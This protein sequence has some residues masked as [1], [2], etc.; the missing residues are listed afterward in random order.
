MRGPS[1][2]EAKGSILQQ[3]L[4]Y[5]R[6]LD[7]VSAAHCPFLAPAKAADAIRHWDSHVLLKSVDLALCLAV[8]C[9]HV[10]MLRQARAAR[11]EAGRLLLCDVI[12]WPMSSLGRVHFAL[13]KRYTKQ[14]FL[15]GKFWPGQSLRSAHDTVVPDPPGPILVIRSSLRHRDLRFFNKKSRP[16]RNDYITA[17][18]TSLCDAEDILAMNTDRFQKELATLAQSS[19]AESRIAFAARAFDCRKMLIEKVS[20]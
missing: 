20:I 10:E 5:N 3:K 13:K 14:E 6:Y 19:T 9:L 15:F 12:T 11:S 18:D 16:F 4:A 17:K 8:G 1:C 7:R 2:V